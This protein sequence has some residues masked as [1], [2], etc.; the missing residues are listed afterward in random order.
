[1]SSS[2][3]PHAIGTGVQGALTAADALFGEGQ[4][5]PAYEETIRRD[6]AQYRRTHWQYYQRE[7]RWPDAPFWAR[8]RTPVRLPAAAVIESVHPLADD[9]EPLHL[10]A[11]QSEVLH[12]HCRPGRPVH[13]IAHTF[14]AAHPSLPDERIILGMQ[15]LVEAGSVVRK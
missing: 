2:G 12:A 11:R 6:V 10:T 5:L 7:A 14:A 8:R 4:M 15:E 9:F 3:I 1:L 13:T